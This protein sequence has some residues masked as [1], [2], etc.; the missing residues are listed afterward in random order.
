[1]RILVVND[2][3]IEAEGIRRLAALA[4]SL[5]ETWVAAPDRPCSGMSQ[6]ITILEPIAVSRYTFPVPGVEGAYACAGTPAD[7]T[8]IAVTYLMEKKPDIIFSGINNGY[9]AGYDIT[10]SGTIGAA[11]EGLMLGVP[12]IAFSHEGGKD[13]AVTEK[14]I[15]EITEH[16]LAG[17]PYRDRIWNVNFP[18]CT[19]EKC[20]GIRW[21]V[22]PA[23]AG[24]YKTA[25]EEVSTETDGMMQLMNADIPQPRSRFP[26]GSDH[27]A[28]A[29][30]Y[31]SVGTVMCNTMP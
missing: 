6:R 10:Y 20:K 28:L 24:F 5:G 26:E 7:C 4:V 31:I 18:E 29:D 3:G 12:A 17:Q 14:Y 23:G 11:M 25:F 1:M 21:G 9:N 22:R 30:G 13:F 19:P 16:I 27:A 8:D 2:D 15:R